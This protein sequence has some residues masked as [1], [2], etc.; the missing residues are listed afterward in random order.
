MA[1][2]EER[3]SWKISSRTRIKMRSLTVIESFSTERL[4]I[5]ESQLEVLLSIHGKL[6]Q[7]HIIDA[8][9]DP[10]NPLHEIFEWD[11]TTAACEHRLLQ[12]RQLIRVVV[13]RPNDESGSSKFRMVGSGRHIQIVRNTGE[14]PKKGRPRKISVMRDE[15][16]YLA[17]E[18]KSDTS[19]KQ[20]QSPMAT[21]VSNLLAET[22]EPSLS[23]ISEGADDGDDTTSSK[24]VFQK[25]RNEI[26]VLSSCKSRLVRISEAI[27]IAKS[28]KTVI[29][30]LE[31]LLGRIGKTCGKCGLRNHIAGDGKHV[32]LEG[33][34]YTG[35]S[36]LGRAGQ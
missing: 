14:G 13:M 2:P 21:R 15:P 36:N 12:A 4:S 23:E 30:D 24:E 29:S 8:A 1:S 32:C 18:N 17:D 20:L 26:I 31:G 33:S 16:K 34:N 6:E 19:V 10:Q 22:L 5:I 7:Q 28:L 35:V 3:Y 9:M 27:D 11:D 25:L